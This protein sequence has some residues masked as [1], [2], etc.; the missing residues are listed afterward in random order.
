M[1]TLSALILGEH[2]IKMIKIARL[3]DCRQQEGVVAG[4]RTARGPT[5]ARWDSNM[6]ARS[7][8]GRLAGCPAVSLS[9]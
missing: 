8:G 4:A 6:A 1:E 3:T 9:L 2:C 7:G 5:A